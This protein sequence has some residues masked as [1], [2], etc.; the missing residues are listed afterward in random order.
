MSAAASAGESPGPVASYEDRLI[1]GGRLAPDILI[2]GQAAG[3]DPGGW[4]RSVSI[5]LTTSGLSNDEFDSAESGIR[6]GGMLDTPN[7]G[8]FTLDASW[9]T[10]DSYGFGSGGLVTVLQRGLPLAGAWSANNVIGAFNTPATDLSRRQYRF[11]VP[12]IPNAGIATEWIHDGDLAFFAAAGEPGLFTGVYVPAFERQGGRL[13]GGGLQWNPSGSLS[14]AVQMVDVSRV[15]LGIGRD[16]DSDSFSARSWFAA[17]SWNGADARAQLNVVESSEDGTSSHTGAWLDSSFRSDW[18]WHNAGAFV[19]GSDLTWGNQ[20]LSS[21][22]QGGYYRATYQDRRWNASGG[23]DYVEPTSGDRSPTTFATGD[24]RYQLR[25]DLGIGGGGNARRGPS[26]AWWAFGYVDSRNRWGTGRGQVGYGRDRTQA[27]AQVALDQ[28]WDT[29]AGRRLSTGLIGNRLELRDETTHTLGIAL[30][31]GGDVARNLVLDANVRYDKGFGDAG[32]D[33]LMANVALNWSFAPGWTA[34]AIYYQN[35]LHR[36]TPVDAVSPIPDPIDFIEESADERGYYLTVRY[37]W[38]AGSRTVPIGGPA[39]RGA[40]RISGV[41]YLDANDNGRMDA[42][43]IATPNV[44]VLLDGRFAARTDG[45]GRFVFPT[46]APGDHYVT[47]VPDN[48]PL[49]WT[50]QDDRRFEVR[51]EARDDARVEIPARRLH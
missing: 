35:R 51:V 28:A 45:G 21:D 25:S 27:A 39:G 41:I 16:P 24:L 37:D 34:S 22:M 44:V 14:A 30:N 36:R 42:G 15:E 38:Q 49:P 48:L 26:D 19:L 5:Q 31:A 40:G 29:T 23:V 17:M 33:D 7:Y 3:H 10:S 8:A 18:L 12:T 32:I 50:V 4:P 47:V 43:E 13:A 20:P 9:R 1:D 6:V 46:V 11:F 2:D